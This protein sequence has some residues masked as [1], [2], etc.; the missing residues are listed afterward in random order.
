[1]YYAVSTAEPVSKTVNY[2]IAVCGLEKVTV[3]QTT[4]LVITKYYNEFKKDYDNLKYYSEQHYS[5]WFALNTDTLVS[6]GLVSDATEANMFKGCPLNDYMLCY[7]NECKDAHQAT[8]LFYLDYQ[9]SSQVTSDGT[10][11]ADGSEPVTP[12]ARRIL[13]A[14]TIPYSYPA[15]NITKVTTRNKEEKY[16]R[17]VMKIDTVY[18]QTAYL[19]ALTTGYAMG[20]R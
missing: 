14:P 15:F 4:E 17:I 19:A 18:T 8:S 6:D 5:S 1:M 10:L 2:K 7:D 9:K 16:S 12:S 13:A 3:S 20:V 11:Q